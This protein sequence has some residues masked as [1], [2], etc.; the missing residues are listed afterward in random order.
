MQSKRFFFV[1]F[2]LL[3][4]LTNSRSNNLVLQAPVV[5]NQYAS[6]PN[7]YNQQSVYGQTQIQSQQQQ[8]Q[9]QSIYQNDSNAT[10]N[11]D[12]QRP[13]SSTSIRRNSRVLNPQDRPSTGGAANQSLNDRSS[14]NY[15]TSLLKKLK[16]SSFVTIL[17]QI[18]P[19][20]ILPGLLKFF[21]KFLPF[22]VLDYFRRI[23]GKLFYV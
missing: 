6:G 22:H 23:D 7:Q 18:D 9:Q 2:F 8:Q 12:G 17:G 16:T 10:T 19:V 1:S 4:F 14:I 11:I 5:P 21:F 20:I 15:T 3:F 13:P